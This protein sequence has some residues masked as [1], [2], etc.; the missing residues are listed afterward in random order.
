[1]DVEAK[2]KEKSAY[3]ANSPSAPA[4]DADNGTEWVRRWFCLNISDDIKGIT[5]GELKQQCVVL[6]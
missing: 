3:S 1:M 6:Q 5:S 2:E 4:T